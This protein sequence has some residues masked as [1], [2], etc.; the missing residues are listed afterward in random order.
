VRN[1]VRR[2]DNDEARLVAMTDKSVRVAQEAEVQI[3]AGSDLL[4]E[5]R[6]ARDREVPHGGAGRSRK[7]A[8]PHRWFSALCS[9]ASA[10]PGLWWERAELW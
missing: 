8:A 10:G 5:Q 9:R 1:F 6:R 2:F 4:A 3:V 7:D